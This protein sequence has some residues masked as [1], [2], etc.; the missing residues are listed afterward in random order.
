MTMF[1]F[2]SY[3]IWLL[4]LLVT[5]CLASM[6]GAFRTLRMRQIVAA[7]DSDH[8]QVKR[9][10]QWRTH[11][12][13][14]VA[15]W[16]ALC[17]L[18]SSLAIPYLLY[19]MPSQ[20]SLTLRILVCVLLVFLLIV[21]GVLMPRYLASYL[22][23]RIALRLMPLLYIWARI[24]Q[25][26]TY[27]LLTP[28]EKCATRC[29][30]ATQ[31]DAPF[32]GEKDTEEPFADSTDTFQEEEHAMLRSVFEFG[33]T[34]VREVMTPRTRMVAIPANTSLDDAIA[35]ALD[36]GHSRLPVYENDF[37]HIVGIFYLRDALTFWKKTDEGALP[38]VDA[39]MHTPFFVPETK[40][41]NELLR[42]FRVNKTQIAIIVDEYAGTAGI[43]TLEDLIEE[44]VGEIH[45]EYD[46]EPTSEY[47]QVDEHT[48]RI[49]A[50]MAVDDLNAYIPVNLPEDEDFDTV[51]GY[52]MSA[53]GHVPDEGETMKKD[54]YTFTILGVENRQITTIEIVHE[55]AS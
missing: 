16:H 4:L 12:R 52:L 22:G 50:T 33:D 17:L 9:W 36:E 44:I 29:G 18:A 40:K 5:G 10:L 26:L 20:A 38:A 28:A 15:I 46:E 25:P 35:R 31:T 39:I 55:P 7:R 42:E 51:G 6:D 37:D 45:D 1:L 8:I 14:S 21:Y 23:T 13:A 2:L 53:L 11:I 19:R 32:N 47:I 41:V 49:N 27:I 34:I 54:D 30:G 3:A 24:T 43:A 48:W